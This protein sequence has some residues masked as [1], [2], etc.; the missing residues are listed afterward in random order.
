MYIILE[1]VM[2]LR[3]SINQ[4]PIE[5]K[6]NKEGIIV[7]IKRKLPF[8]EIKENLINKLESYVGF[9][10]GAKISK[11]NSEYLDD[12]EILQLKDS[13]TSK[14]DVEFI[15][16]QLIE[17]LANF[18]TKYVKSLRS[19]ELI[20]CDG[21][22]VVLSDMKPGSEVVST[23]N[24]VVM[25]DIQS[26][27]KVIAGGNVTVMGSILGFVH[28]GS[29]GNQSAYVVSKNLRPKVLKIAKVIAEA[30]DDEECGE[31]KDSSPEIAYVS[32]DR[33][34][35]ESYLSFTVK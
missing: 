10:N 9:F 35:I 18:D 11:I 24:T 20:E 22:V 1:V 7:N 17:E 12:I 8:E 33:I 32:N 28:A 4:E 19:G 16:E 31:E 6:G 13:I 34:V 14:F 15:E 27:A 3:E 29:N 30:P 23:L 21:D 2:S 25:G 5:F 26:G